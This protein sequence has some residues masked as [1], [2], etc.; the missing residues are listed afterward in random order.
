MNTIPTQLHPNDRTPGSQ[1]Q[2]RTKQ[3]LAKKGTF[4]STVGA[5]TLP[6]RSPIVMVT[7]EFPHKSEGEVLSAYRLHI[8]L[9]YRGV[10][11]RADR[12]RSTR[13]CNSG[14]HRSLIQRHQ[15]H[16]SRQ[17]HQT[18]YAPKRAFHTNTRLSHS[19]IERKPSIK[20]NTA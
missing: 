4:D 13:L 15:P 17:P 14:T 11:V 19:N 3:L 8:R 2:R 20:E 7:H 1:N 9:K 12:L 6:G 16:Q 5:S 18:R 10:L